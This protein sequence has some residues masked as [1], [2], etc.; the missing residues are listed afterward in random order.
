MPLKTSDLTANLSCFPR[1]ICMNRPSLL[2]NT[3][4]AGHP[5]FIIGGGTIKLFTEFEG[6]AFFLND[7]RFFLAFVCYLRALGCSNDKG[8]GLGLS[9][10][11]R[12]K[13][14]WAKILKN[15]IIS[16]CASLFARAG[17]ST[18]RL[19]SLFIQGRLFRSGGIPGWNMSGRRWVL[20]RFGG[21]TCWNT[22]HRNI[23][24][25][26]CQF[27]TFFSCLARSHFLN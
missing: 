15:K 2:S 6:H 12:L 8:W 25:R 22:R 17:N 7:W 27:L 9:G 10:P 16:V 18:P 1:I 5:S 19:T 20:T 14:E 3:A 11:L 24:D 26:D 4:W 21:K 13:P 23:T